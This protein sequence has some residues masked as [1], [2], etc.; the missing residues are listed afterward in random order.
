MNYPSPELVEAL[1][2]LGYRLMRLLFREAKEA[3][4]RL[5]FTPLQAEV[6]RRLSEGNPSP[7]QLAEEMEMSPSQTSSLLAHLEDRGLLERAPDPGDRRRVLLQLTEEGRRQ[8][9]A[10]QS[11]WHETFARHLSRLGSKELLAFKEILEKLTEEA[12]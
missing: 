7:T 3:F 1:T 4:A 6:L 9:K 11:I 5:G 12:A 2:Q 8:V 10:L